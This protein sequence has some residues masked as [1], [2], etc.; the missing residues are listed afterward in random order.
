VSARQ[1]SL[2][3][4]H[5][6]AELSAFPIASESA[7]RLGGCVLNANQ[8]ALW[9][10][11]EKH[12]LSHFPGFGVD[13]IV[14]LRDQLWF[15]QDNPVNL[16]A[17]LTTLSQRCANPDQQK[18]LYGL[19]PSW[20]TIRRIQRWMTFA[21]P[22][23]L[24]SAGCGGNNWSAKT[25]RLSPLVYRNLQDHGYAETHLHIG[26]AITF[27]LLWVTLLQTIASD[28]TAE[29][30]FSSP[31]ADFDSGQQL[32]PWLLRACIVR[33]VLAAFLAYRN[34]VNPKAN[35]ATYLTDIVIPKIT[36]KG[37]A[38]WGV[39]MQQSHQQLLAGHLHG[40]THWRL[41]QQ[42]YKGLT[43]LKNVGFPEAINDIYASDPITTLVGGADATISAE[44]RFMIAALAYKE[45][46]A[47]FKRLFWQV[48]RLR[49]CFYRHVVQRPMTPGLQW[50]LRFY[51]RMGPAKY[52]LS[53]ASH[54]TSAAKIQGWGQGLRALEIRLGL[55]SDTS[56]LF[57]DLK[58]MD[59]VRAQLSQ[60]GVTAAEF[61]VIFHFI[62]QRA[63]HNVDPGAF[64]Q[65]G[66]A[67]PRQGENQ[68]YRYAEFYR[69]KKLEAITLSQLLQNVPVSLELI[70][71]LDVCTDELGIPNWVIA[72]CLRLARVGGKIAANK[73]LSYHGMRVPPL[74]TTAHAGEDFVHLLS[75]LRQVDEAIQQ[76]ELHEGD[77]IGH[78]ISLG[79]DPALWCQSIGR[80]LL[81]KETRLL[82]LAWE[83][84]CYSQKCACAPAGREVVIQQELATLSRAIFDT[85]MTPYEALE[86]YN[87]LY[88]APRLAS[89]GFPD[90]LAHRPAEAILPNDHRQQHLVT[91]LTDPR[92]FKTCHELTWI[93][94]RDELPALTALQNA[95]RHKV[96]K[97][98][99]TIEVNPSSNLLIGNLT[100]L[101]RHPLWRLRPPRGNSDVPPVAICV[102]SDDPLTF[103]TGIRE[104]YQ[105]LNDALVYAG[106]SDDEARAWLDD[107]RNTSLMAR[108]TLQRSD[109]PLIPM[110]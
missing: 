42:M 34:H 90:G 83:W 60:P 20:V 26:A 51:A 58:K 87:D 100:D 98:G 52:P 68:G 54:I 18:D 19:A 48:M 9:L 49:N 3:L 1:S 43:G 50:F 77:R 96:G 106:L 15:S 21:L 24:T 110:M 73:L 65:H 7:F 11:A 38:T 81:S 53:L 30:A 104:E 94:P 102:G 80:I 27:P 28:D 41:L 56:A 105:L 108:F 72:P 78:A 25:H 93:E 46:D 44:K 37:G 63:A 95:L 74:R 10:A 84:G 40:D 66:Y 64:N 4:E 61:G 16:D 23:D 14:A 85:P 91:F 17:Y 67:N 39:L 22:R 6:I 2:P 86:F 8:N 88:D 33:Y 62:K 32:A 79:T 70:R 57:N 89:A 103:A 101:E 76:F 109:K 5:L 31:N 97:R 13:E 55:Y 47:L 75:G 92:C 12:L 71:G 45:D 36:D 69:S 59:E 99:I 35:F 107:V 82:D 29:V